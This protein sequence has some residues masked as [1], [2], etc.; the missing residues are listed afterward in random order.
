VNAVDWFSP[1]LAP[2]VLVPGGRVGF[3][4][5]GPDNGTPLLLCHRFR[6]TIDDWDPA[7]L[8]GLASVM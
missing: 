7:L 1:K 2:S 3:R 4:R 5:A 6:G 8:N